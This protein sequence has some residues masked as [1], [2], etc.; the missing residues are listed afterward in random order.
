[1]EDGR[2]RIMFWKSSRKLGASSDS[3]SL[4]LSDLSIKNSQG[5]GD[6]GN[7]DSK[8]GHGSGGSG[9][10]HF[11]SGIQGGSIGDSFK[12]K[13]ATAAMNS[14]ES[15]FIKGL[16]MSLQMEAVGASSGDFDIN[17]E[18]S[19][20]TA[21]KD[22]YV[23]VGVNELYRHKLGQ[24]IFS[25]TE[26]EEHA[27]GQ[28][29]RHLLVDD[30]SPVL[31]P[32]DRRRRRGSLQSLVSIEKQLARHRSSRGF[33]GGGGGDDTDEA[34]IASE[35]P[36]A[37]GRIRDDHSVTLKP[38]DRRRRRDSLQSL[39]SIE[40]QLGKNYLPQSTNTAGGTSESQRPKIKSQSAAAEA[41]AKTPPPPSAHRRGR[42]G[43]VTRRRRASLT[44]LSLDDI[45]EDKAQVDGSVPGVNAATSN[46]T[47]ADAGSGEE[48]AFRLKDDQGNDLMLDFDKRRTSY[49]SELSSLGDSLATSN[50][51]SMGEWEEL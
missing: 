7:G 33:G 39:V 10:S 48:M 16:R 22:K 49:K 34:S 45:C 18:D 14:R 21:N 11:K 30:H 46:A 2:N 13:I 20:D 3:C 1:M 51:S 12:N 25:A 6:G 8:N 37:L 50:S 15:D 24:C 44:S 32:L 47:G 40:K 29:Q 43:S 23:E 9:S 31:N 5:C 27:L 26:R 36:S 42:R 35:S 17:G 41:A 28:S 4:Q 19:Q 38:I